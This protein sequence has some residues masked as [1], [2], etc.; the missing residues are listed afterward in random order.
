MEGGKKRVFKLESR[1]E[2]IRDSSQALRVE[3]SYKSVQLLSQWI[4]SKALTLERQK[5]NPLKM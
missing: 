1:V 5:T 2:E 3:F 4:Y